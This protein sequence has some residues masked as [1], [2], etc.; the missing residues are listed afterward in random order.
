M[1]NYCDNELTVS[2]S[3]NDIDRFYQENK[4]SIEEARALEVDD[5][6]EKELSFLKSVPIP[7][8]EQNCSRHV[9]EW[10]TKWDASEIH[11][12]KT[13]TEIRYYFQTA[14]SPPVAWLEKTSQRYPNLE[15]EMESKEPGCDFYVHVIVKNGEQTFSKMSTYQ[16]YIYEKYKI[17]DR[18]KK[19]YRIFSE[20]PNV[21]KNIIS[22]IYQDDEIHIEDMEQFIDQSPDDIEDEDEDFKFVFQILQEELNIEEDT[23]ARWFICEALNEFFNE[24]KEKNIE[25]IISILTSKVIE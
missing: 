1:P 14:W 6:E 4:L 12:D 17:N 24:H 3:N 13:D 15:F 8:D 16:E 9:L 5:S 2:G 19:V 20:Y 25:E 22:D 23:D 18:L 21:T 11:S 10:G 7:S